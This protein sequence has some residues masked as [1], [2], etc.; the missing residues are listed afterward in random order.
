MNSYI[1]S[2]DGKFQ[3]RNYL[4][5]AS[6]YPGYYGLIYCALNQIT[7][8]IYIGGVK[9]NSIERAKRD[10]KNGKVEGA[11]EANIG[12]FDD[13]IFYIID[14]AESTIQ[15]DQKQTSWT[16]YFTALNHKTSRNGRF[17]GKVVMG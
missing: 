9:G 2:I 4:T 3:L 17:V 8:R 1:E 5:D 14:I 11:R 7:G 6:S 13:L 16:D 15:I 10:H 12:S